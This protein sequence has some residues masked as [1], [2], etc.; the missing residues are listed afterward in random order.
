MRSRSTFETAGSQSI[1]ADD[2]AATISSTSPSVSISAGVFDQ[3]GF[4]GLSN[5]TAGAAETVTVVAEDIYG[6]EVS[7]FTGTVD[8]SSSDPHMTGLPASYD[9]TS[10]AHAFTINVRDSGLA[11]DHG[12]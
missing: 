9:F 2:V 11:V 7:S 4:A 6:N 1:T 8:F 12:G 3:F 5:G 10:P